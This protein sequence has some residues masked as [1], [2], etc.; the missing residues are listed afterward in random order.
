MINEPLVDRDS[1]LLPPLRINLGLIKQFVKALDKIGNYFRCI[2]STFPGA[3][4]KKVRAGIFDGP[5]IRTLMRVPAFV[6]HMTVV[7]SSAWC[8]YI[9]VVKE[10]LGKTKADCYQ[11]IVKQ[12]LTNFQALESRMSIKFHYLFSHLGRFPD[13]LGEVSE[14]QGESFH[15]AIKNME[16]RYQGQWDSRMMSDYC[17]SLMRDSIQQNYKWKS[18]ERA[19]QQ[20][21]LTWTVKGKPCF[22]YA[23]INF[24]AIQRR[25]SRPPNPPIGGGPG[26]LWGPKLV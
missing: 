8:S 20:I 15:Q 23:D 13:N 16:M 22:V 1:I 10:F 19:L 9:S 6:L 14:K 7:E 21:D 11:D 26:Q 17:W 4:Y 25:S 5:Q 12:M 2:R 18:Y 24:S 3:S